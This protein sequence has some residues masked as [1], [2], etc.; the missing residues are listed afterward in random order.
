MH[1]STLQHFYDFI[2]DNH[3]VEYRELLQ[4]LIDSEINEE[5][6]KLKENID[7]Y[8]YGFNQALHHID[9]YESKTDIR[10]DG[11][12][13]SNIVKAEKLDKKIYKWL[14]NPE[15]DAEV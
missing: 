7:I 14:N 11:F 4:D 2:E 6:E 8:S 1:I 13:S 9:A 12:D 10:L 3:G 5:T 15:Y